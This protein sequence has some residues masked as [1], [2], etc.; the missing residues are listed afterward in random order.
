LRE[1]KFSKDTVKD[2]VSQRLWSRFY[3][4]MRRSTNPRSKLGMK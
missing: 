3:E 1:G 4:E 2:P